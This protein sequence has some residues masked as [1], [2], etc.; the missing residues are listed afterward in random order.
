MLSPEIATMNFSTSDWNDRIR[1]VVKGDCPTI[2][3]LK[4]AESAM[5]LNRVLTIAYFSDH[6]ESLD[7]DIDG[8]SYTFSP[9]TWRAILS[10]TD[11]W[12]EQYLPATHPE[13]FADE[14]Q[15]AEVIQLFA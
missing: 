6:N 14:P 13:L 1:L 9:V 5:E 3:V 2:I 8:S 4:S 12:M 11:Q 10:C 7:V 15:S